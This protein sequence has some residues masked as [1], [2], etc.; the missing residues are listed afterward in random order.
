MTLFPQAR[1]VLQS[2][3]A[4]LL[5]LLLLLAGCGGGGDKG[6]NKDKDVPKAAFGD[7]FQLSFASL[8]AQFIAEF[9]K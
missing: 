1:F 7:R 2:G 6:K 9:S 8:P 4:L 3:R 5:G